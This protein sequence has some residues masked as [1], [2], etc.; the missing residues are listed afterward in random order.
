[1]TPNK[2]HLLTE[3]R[4]IS[5][6][7]EA[8]GF[9]AMLAGGCV[10][11]R[12]LEQEPNDFDLA[13]DATPEQMLQ[14][15][16]QLKWRVIPVGIEH[17]TLSVVTELQTIDITTLRHD[18]NCDGRHAEVQFTHSFAED[19]KRRDFTINA[20]FEDRHGRIHDFVGGLDDLKAKRLRFVGD[21]EA[22]IQEDYLRSLRYFRFLARLGWSPEAAQINAIRGHREGMRQ[23]SME[24]VLAEYNKLQLADHANSVLH[25]MDQQGIHQVLFPWYQNN[26]A[27]AL[28]AEREQVGGQ[29]LRLHWF[30]FL[31]HGGLFRMDQTGVDQALSA[32]RMPRKS[33]RLFLVLARLCSPDRGIGEQASDVLH[34]GEQ[35]RVDFA[36]FE[37]FLKLRVPEI[38]TL[39][40]GLHQRPQSPAAPH[41]WLMQQAPPLRGRLV[42]AAKICW[43][44]G[45]WDGKSSL[46]ELSPVQSILQ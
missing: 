20:L 25:L 26:A 7:F 8:A 45:L 33:K 22:R 35:K 18:L 4:Q 44:L 9:R 17:G 24:R 15:A 27:Q 2:A 36:S 29:D 6:C 1:M 43:Y 3:V 14:L 42:E 12:L 46:S 19:A 21:A 32:M 30:L 39:W 11:D 23:L 28:I 41:D 5:A 13:T 38:V 37:R 34:L 10:R 40:Q 31:W 16:K